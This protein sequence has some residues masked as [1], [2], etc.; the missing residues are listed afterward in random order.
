MDPYTE[1]GRT[2]KPHG[3]KG[4]LK[5]QVEEIFEKAALKATAFFLES[6]GQYIPLFVERISK[7]NAIILKLEDYNSKEEVTAISKKPLFMRSK[8]AVVDES[9]LENNPHLLYQQLEGFQL[10]DDEVG[11]IGQI[12]RVIEMPQ[13]SLALVEYNGKEVMIP[14]HES[15][16]LSVDPEKA[17]IEMSLPEGLLEL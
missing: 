10:I 3:L 11:A 1:I 7:G 12:D 9:V 5:I 4:E 17:T 8:D 16:I 14:L 2:I 13:Q 6:N 15:L